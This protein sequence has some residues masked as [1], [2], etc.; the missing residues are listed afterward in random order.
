M[1]GFL[2]DV[3]AAL[4]WWD[5]QS[6]LTEVRFRAALLARQFDPTACLLS[7]VFSLLIG[8]RM[9]A[10]DFRSVLFA[11]QCFDAFS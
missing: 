9:I 10:F 7:S 1:K 3:C 6:Y 2:R 5:Y 11:H 4:T 8:F